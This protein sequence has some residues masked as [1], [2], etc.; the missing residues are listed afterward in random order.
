[1]FKNERKVIRMTNKPITISMLKR[2]CE[3]EIAKGNGSK[4]IMISNDDEGN[5]FHYLWYS[6][7]SAKEIVD[8]E[9]KYGFSDLL[10]DIDE[11]IAKVEDTIILG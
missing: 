8:E 3:R 4:S 10:D 5:G 2:M 11:K 7:T 6:F 9:K 1:M